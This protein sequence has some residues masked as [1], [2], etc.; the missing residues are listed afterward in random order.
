MQSETLNISVSAYSLFNV[1]IYLHKS[2]TGLEQYCHVL[3]QSHQPKRARPGKK[4]RNVQVEKTQEF[5]KKDEDYFAGENRPNSI[6]RESAL[7]ICG[8]MGDPLLINVS[9]LLTGQ[10]QK[11]MTDSVSDN[12]QEY[13]LIPNP[14]LF[15]LSYAVKRLRQPIPMDG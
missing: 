5:P 3:K 7:L 2:T 14:H 8:I 4:I 6:L 11:F 1:I 15:Y 13:C 12:K 10:R 9:S